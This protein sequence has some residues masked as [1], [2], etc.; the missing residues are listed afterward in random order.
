MSVNGA[1]PGLI[2]NWSMARERES[3]ALVQTEIWVKECVLL[4][5][6]VAMSY[7]KWLEFLQS[8][9]EIVD[10]MGRSLQ[11]GCQCSGLGSKCNESSFFKWACSKLGNLTVCKGHSADVTTEACSV[12]SCKHSPG[13][14]WSIFCSTAVLWPFTRWLYSLQIY[15]ADKEEERLFS[16]IQW[17]DCT[18]VKPCVPFPDTGLGSWIVCSMW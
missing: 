1:P 6:N 8:V 11:G 12:A 9:A 7:I 3:G 2:G 14:S 4:V 10:W 13:G 5:C 16:E 18:T 17:A 15:L